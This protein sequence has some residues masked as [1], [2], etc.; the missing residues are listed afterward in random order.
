VMCVCVCV[1]VCVYVRSVLCQQQKESNNMTIISQCRVLFWNNS[2]RFS[3]FLSLS[4]MEKGQ[5]RIFVSVSVCIQ[6]AVGREWFDITF[7]KSNGVRLCNLGRFL[8]LK[9]P[10]LG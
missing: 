9:P 1:C 8:F 4:K 3:V 5:A 6:R 7:I 2:M 10:L